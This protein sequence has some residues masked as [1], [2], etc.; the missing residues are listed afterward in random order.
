MQVYICTKEFDLTTLNVTVTVGQTVSKWDGQILSL[1]D[2]VEW[3]NKAFYDWIGEADSL[4]YISFVGSIPDPSPSGSGVPQ[5]PSA[6]PATPTS[7]GTQGTWAWD[8]T[9]F[10]WCRA[11]NIWIRWV[12]E[13]TW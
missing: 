6:A 9:Y 8:G 3:P 11:T 1:V 7:A 2:T 4:N 13:R 5:T 10:Y 12:V